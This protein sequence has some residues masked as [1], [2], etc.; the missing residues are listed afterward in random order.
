MRLSDLHVSIHH[1]IRDV[2]V[3]GERFRMRGDVAVVDSFEL[4]NG[5][6]HVADDMAC[7]LRGLLGLGWIQSVLLEE[8]GYMAFTPPRGSDRLLDALPAHKCVLDFSG[9]IVYGP[10]PELVSDDERPL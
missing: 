10:L 6:A 9:F 1:R 7:T 2:A 8:H 3:R 5:P 4:D